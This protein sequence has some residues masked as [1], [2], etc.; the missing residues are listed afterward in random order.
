PN[1]ALPALIAAT[2]L[3]RWPAVDA[4]NALLLAY[5]FANLATVYALA[6]TETHHVGA[7]ALA[8]VIFGLSPY[9]AVHLLGHFDL[10]AAFPDPLSRA[11]PDSRRARLHPRRH[12]RRRRA[13]RHGLHR[14][15]PSRLPVLLRRALS[16]CLEPSAQDHTRQFG[17][18]AGRA[19]P[20]AAL[21]GSRRRRR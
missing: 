3:G 6:W 9:V 16:H 1:T 2:L 11:C 13:R 7:S 15:L 17:G 12:C 10:V 14:V 8:A 20:R 5:V 18:V 4:Q 19:A 21:R